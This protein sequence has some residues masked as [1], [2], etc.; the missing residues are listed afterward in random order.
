MD[1][2]KRV[3]IERPPRRELG[4]PI[5]RHEP[6][7]EVFGSWSASWSSLL[8]I[9]VE[10]GLTSPRPKVPRFPYSGTDSHGRDGTERNDGSFVYPVSACSTS[11]T[12]CPTQRSLAPE[13][14]R[15]SNAGFPPPI[16]PAWARD[17]RAGRP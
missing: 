3:V 11:A 17:R 13:P 14:V 10:D 1:A 16:W 12:K 15:L 5:N 9:G 2:K 4:D 6:E 8:H 7:L